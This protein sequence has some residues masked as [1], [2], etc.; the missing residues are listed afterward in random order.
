[1]WRT[2]KKKATGPAS[3]VSLNYSFYCKNRDSYL[4]IVA[5]KLTDLYAQ[6]EGTPEAVLGVAENRISCIGKII[7]S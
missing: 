4:L 6:I 5:I 3:L 2:L 7:E 1:M